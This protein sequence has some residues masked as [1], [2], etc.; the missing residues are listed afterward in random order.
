MK[1]FKK[2]PKEYKENIMKLSN[3]TLELIA[4]DIFDL[5]SVEELKRYF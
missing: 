4:I 2:L 1:K 5:N 3:D